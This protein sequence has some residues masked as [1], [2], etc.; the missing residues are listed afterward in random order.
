MPEIAAVE[1]ALEAAVSA[2][3]D[4][5]E[6]RPGQREMC[7]AV[8]EAMDSG[9]HLV[10]AA[11][12]GT[13]K[14]LAYLVP[15]VMGEGPSVVATATKTLQDQ[16]VEKDLPQLAD[17][18]GLPVRFAVLKG[19]SNYLCV[20]RLKEHTEDDQLSLDIA[21]G[22]K[23]E[24][25][26]LA[27]WAGQTDTGDRA[28]LDFEPSHAAWDALSVSGRECPGAQRCPSGS[29]CFAEKARN[30][31]NTADIVVVNTHLY[32][33]HL[34]SETPLLPEH[35]TVVVDE[36]HGLEDIVSDTAGLSL[37]GG[38][39]DELARSIRSVVAQSAAADEVADAGARLPAAPP[40]GGRSGGAPRAPR[41]VVPQRA[42]ADEVADA[43][44]RLREAL[45]PFRD[46]PLPAPLPEELQ[47]VAVL[48]RGRVEQAAGELR[49]VPDDAPGD[50]GPR[51]LRAV[52]AAGALMED[53]AR[54]V[55]S[56]ATEVAWVS[57]P[58]SSP[59]W[60]I[61]PI[62][63]GELLSE[64]LWEHT[65]AVLTSATIPMNLGEILGLA[66]DD[67]DAINVG[68]PFDY[69]AN[70]LLYCAKHLP[71]PRSPG[72]ESAIHEEL[73]ALITAA[74]G[75]TLALF[76]SYRAL[77]RAV[78]VL[79]EELD[80]PIYSQRDLPKAELLRR[81]AAE[82]ESCLFA[83]MSMWQ[84][85]DIPGEALSLVAIDRLPFPRPDDPLLEA[86]RERYGRNAFRLIDLPRA[87]T[88]L[89]QGAG[90]LI[91]RTTDRGVVAVLDPRMAT[92]GYR[93]ELVNALPPFPRTAERD[94][95]ETMLRM[96][97]DGA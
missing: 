73:A 8:A 86:R 44:L 35:N 31:A 63:L 71:D 53:L 45:A 28:E 84:G 59:A 57:G 2:L 52:L 12:T 85:V 92:A 38:R 6:R 88:R 70:T 46:K 54:A 9:R 48:A 83:T 20:Q 79:R 65:T 56:Q 29:T 87:A 93:W 81:F 10:V 75:R 7:E 91:R 5:G 95:A 43:G 22:S 30:N 62:Q 13:G 74:G 55:E 61:A 72:Y 36:A 58:E 76:T 49:A 78:E 94:Q 66:P 25:S 24:I 68:S 37:T 41:A 21:E 82:V 17:A 51:K 23:A 96:I 4:G 80:F 16:L 27:A 60:R 14:S 47:D 39:F 89:A 11:G 69:E 3:E 77:D 19:R 1:E 42:A 40:P 33:L 32:C 97:R 67:H 64:R 34:F 15:L 26:R 18:L 50:V 90:R